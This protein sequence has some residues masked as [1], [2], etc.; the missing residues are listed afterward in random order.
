MRTLA[1]IL[2]LA[3]SS[4]CLALEIN[5]QATWSGLVELQ[6]D[7]VIADG[8]SLTIAPAT[9]VITNGHRIIC[10]GK[11]DIQAEETAW[12]RFSYFPSTDSKVEVVKVKPYDVD[13]AILQ[14]EFNIFKVQY[15][16]LW[17]LLFASTFVML[18]AR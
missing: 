10:Y 17:S 2:I 13:T 16:I 5:G 6:E 15:A 18:E 12:V 14:E 4:H 9:R 7:V 1:V 8:A 3:L 11:V